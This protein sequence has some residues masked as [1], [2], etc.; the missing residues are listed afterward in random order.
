M[1]RKGPGFG[2]VLGD[3]CWLMAQSAHHKH[4]FLADLEW[5]VIPALTA[6]QFRVLKA[7]TKPMAYVS[8]AHLSED[9]E[10]RLLSG[11]PRLRPADW[12]SGDRL[13]VID[14]VAPFGGNDEI[15]RT[16]KKQHFADVSIRS[17]RP[18]ADGKGFEAWEIP[19]GD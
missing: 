8:W 17:L 9:A 13:W 19:S 16:L 14:V 12:K 2:E 3:I 6:R 15:L 1:A 11:Q 18:R 4:I 10:A 7:G 5:L